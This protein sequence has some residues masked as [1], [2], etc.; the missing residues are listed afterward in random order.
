MKQALFLGASN[1]HGVGLH[2]FRDFYKDW[3]NVRAEWP[4]KETGDDYQFIDENRFSKKLSDYLNVKEFNYSHAGGSPA[5]ALHIL[6][7][8]D[9]TD[10]EYIFFE[11]SSIYSYFDRFFHTHFDSTIQKAVPRTPNEIEAFLT[12]G[13]NDDSELKER[14]IQWLIDYNPKEFMKE[15]FSKLVEFI[16]LHPHI[17]F[18]ILIW[19]EELDS[20]NI[21]LQ[22]LQ[23]Y[24]VKFPLKPE[25]DNILVEKYLTCKSLRVCDEFPYISKLPFPVTHSD[26]HP[27]LNG[28]QR[29]FEILKN[30]INEK[31]N[32]NTW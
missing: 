12:N 10:V 1:T 22:F 15:I 9:L 3:N 17:K 20:Q 7:K 5:E 18:S 32:T 8:T 19:R 21:D 16:K 26:L 14:I 31:N 29:I 28:H 23:K 4:Y 30:H 2:F 6:S 13:K 25:P 27:S 11:L 24:I